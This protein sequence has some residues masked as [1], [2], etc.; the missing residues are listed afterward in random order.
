MNFKD[1]KTGNIVFKCD[2]CRTNF[3]TGE[4]AFSVAKQVAEQEG[5]KARMELGQWV[6]SC[7]KCRD[8]Y[9]SSQMQEG[10]PDA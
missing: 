5:F 7:Q 2:E 3:D 6:H 1:K 8:E 4:T 10:D 9:I